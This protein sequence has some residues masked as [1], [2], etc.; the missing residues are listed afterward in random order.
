MVLGAR[1]SSRR[2]LRGACARGERVAAFYSRGRAGTGL[3]AFT[4]KHKGARKGVRPPLGRVR[5]AGGSRGWGRRGRATPGARQARGC[6][7]SRRGRGPRVAMR[8]LSFRSWG[9][10]AHGAQ[11]RSAR[12]A[13]PQRARAPG[14]CGQRDFD[15]DLLQIFELSKETCEYQSCR[16]SY[17]LQQLRKL[18]YVLVNGLAK[19]ASGKSAFA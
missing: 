8:H 3:H 5:L 12:T 11:G 4:M 19:N 9:A 13:T 18:T 14:F 6:E 15:R 10:M 7:G 2:R 17:P 1:W 16:L